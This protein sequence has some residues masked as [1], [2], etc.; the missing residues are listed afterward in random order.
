M[1]E[2]EPSRLTQEIRQSPLFQDWG[3]FKKP[4]D[5]P[6][7]HV[8]IASHLEYSL[9]RDQ[10]TARSRDLYQAL[11]LSVRDRLMER[12]VR[13]QQVHYRK[14]VKRVF[15]L[16]AEYLLGRAL[17]N[18]LLALGMLDTARQAMAEMGLDLTDLLEEEPDAGLG[19][20]G[21]GRLAA[22][23]LDSMATLEIPAVGYGIRYEFGIFEQAI[24][25]N[26]QVE[27][28]EEWLK[29]GNPWEIC[30][31]ERS[32]AVGLYGHTEHIT[33]PDGRLRVLWHHGT[34]VLGLAFDTPVAGYRNDTVNTLRLWSAR[35]GTEF[36]LGSFQRGDYLSAVA[37]KSS[38]ENISKVLYPSDD[39]AAGR[40]LRLKQEYFFVSCSVQDI[41]RRHRVMH[42]GFDDLPDRAAIQMNDTHPALAVAELMRLL[43]DAHG[44]PWD[45]A[46]DIT[47]ATC[48]YTNHTLLAEALEKWPVEMFGR[49]LPRHLEIVYEINRRFLGAVS[50]RHPGDDD[51]ARRMSLIE[52]RPVRS[53]RMAHLAMAGSHAING[54]ARI[55]MRL[56]MEHELRDFAE[57]YP[58]RFSAK[59]NGITP[60]RWLLAANPELAALV[61]EAIGPEW[62][63]DL[64]RIAELERFATDPAFV[65]RWRGVR[66]ENKE[67]LA[68]LAKGE[69]GVNVNPGSLYDVQVKR[70]HEYKRQL[71]NILHVVVLWLL[72]REEPHF[73]VH[74]RTFFFGGKAAPGYHAARKIIE[75]ISRVAEVLNRDRATSSML[76]VAF[77]PNYRVSLAE[78]IIPAADVSEHIS[79]AG[80]E[81]SGTS[82]MKFALNG[83]LTIGTLDGA[84]IEIMEEVG[85]ENVFIFGLTADEV[86]AVLPHHDPRAIYEREPRLRQA[87]DLVASGHF[88]GGDAG[89]FRELCDDLL[90]HDRYLVL[91][92]FAAYHAVQLEVDRA[93]RD[94]PG[95]AAKSIRNVA[96]IGRFSSDRTV[97]EY[98]RDIWHAPPVAVTRT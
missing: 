35:A 38:S 53:V 21:L 95:W 16:S 94:A 54:V 47:V 46:W 2:E 34:E 7:L 12:W 11:A 36:D 40:E 74:P 96:R 19:N 56:M 17:T 82:N 66:R 13:T 64:A 22:C 33:D 3:T 80:Y 41:L 29:H 20:G 31:P 83:A 58:E 55:H 4:L 62:T 68:R 84:N 28:P 23:L 5:A 76:K 97:T 57:L 52:E 93:H 87:I 9:A 48:A 60:R 14:D 1:D 10:Y 98:N 77:L 8:A 6:A 71:L 24:R 59:T 37:E 42:G 49:I 27:L 70:I 30:R 26:R 63:R 92:D 65:A 72:L 89:T 43:V 25:G 90:T 51:R 44:V 39:I 75:L 45:R 15:Y 85:R 73:L 88:S 81:A 18:N 91:A 78:R 67:R 50:A 32:C 69:A 61:T 79:T 86:T